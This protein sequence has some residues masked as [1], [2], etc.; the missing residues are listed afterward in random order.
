MISN[1]IISEIWIN[2][3]SNGLKIS[4]EI[5]QNGEKRRVT[6]NP[7][8]IPEIVKVTGTVKLGRVDLPARIREEDGIIVDVGNFT[9][10]VWLK[11]QA[12]EFSE[13]Y[14]NVKVNDE[15]EDLVENLLIDVNS[16]KYISKKLYELIN[17]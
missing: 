8:L 13:K 10:E 17:D 12:K 15:I 4:I 7:R 16:I 5:E 3:F 6:F 2:E 1:C 11:E 9:K 14:K